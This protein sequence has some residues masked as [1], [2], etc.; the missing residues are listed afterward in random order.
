MYMYM[1]I[2]NQPWQ[3]TYIVCTHMHTNRCIYIQ[4]MCEWRVDLLL[5]SWSIPHLVEMILYFTSYIYN[6][7]RV[8]MYYLVEQHSSH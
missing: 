3:I 8:R 5:S 2:C 7:Y 4:C 6:V 1:C